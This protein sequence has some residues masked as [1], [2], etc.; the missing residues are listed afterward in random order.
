MSRFPFALLLIPVILVSCSQ[1][2]VTVDDSLQKY[3]DSAGVKGTFGL[4]DNGQGNFTIYNLSRFRDSGYQPGET[5]D[6]LE[7]LVAIQT[8]AI[9]DSNSLIYD[10]AHFKEDSALYTQHNPHPPLTLRQCFQA[11]GGYGVGG[12]LALVNRIGEDTLKKW[13]DSVH[14]GKRDASKHILVSLTITPDE[15]LGLIKKLYFEQLPFFRRPQQIVRRMMTVEANAN[16][17][18]VYKKASQGSTPDGRRTGWVLGWIEEN[19]HPYFFVINLESENRRADLPAAGMA[20]AHGI[21]SQLGFFQ[22]KR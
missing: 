20:I 7:S 19:K 17:E 4:F 6:I 9:K 18:L 10:P 11:D 15:Q 14:Y 13:V 21:L 16:Y 22:G 12:F 3:F 2:N 1:N 5:F 8:G